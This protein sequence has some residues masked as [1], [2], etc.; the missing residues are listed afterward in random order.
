MSRERKYCPYC[1][2]LIGECECDEQRD[3][4]FP[5][6]YAEVTYNFDNPEA[7]DRARFDDLMFLRYFER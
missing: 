1:G 7:G 3:E 6:G 4:R 2:E 5:Y